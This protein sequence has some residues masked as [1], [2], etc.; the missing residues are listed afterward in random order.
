M[1]IPIQTKTISASLLYIFGLNFLW[2]ISQMFLY[3]KHSD[4]LI[5]F[6]FVHIKASL[7]DVLIFIIIYIIGFFIFK[8]KKW[9]L[10][11]K[12]SVYIFSAVCGFIIAVIIE[13]YALSTGRWAYNDLMPMIPLLD[14]GLLPILQ[15]ILLPLFFTKILKNKSR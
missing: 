1:K 4:R 14:V 15:M 9:F 7:G 11:R 8:N 5:D 6:V 2:E 13:R 10:L 12:N 3:Q